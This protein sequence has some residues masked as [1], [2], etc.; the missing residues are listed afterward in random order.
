[1]RA[2]T[3]D[4]PGW[5]AV[6]PTSKAVEQAAASEPGGV[7][8]AAALASVIR[9]MSTLARAGALPARVERVEEASRRLVVY[10]QRH[11]V[12]LYPTRDGDAYRLVRTDPLTF[13]DHERLLRASVLLRCPAGFRPV[14]QLRDLRG[15]QGL[16]AYWP[17]IT[18]AWEAATAD[19]PVLDGLPPQHADYLDLL[20]EAV[21]ATRDIEIEKQSSA[22]PMPY[23]SRGA[24]QAQRD[25]ARGLYSFRL[26]RP[27][28]LAVGAPVS[29][30]DEPGLRGRVVHV[31]DGE[32]VIRFDDAIDYR[33]I[34]PQG[35]LR[36]LPSERVYRAQLAAIDVLREGRA[37][38]P[39]LLETLVDRRLASYSPDGRA[40]PSRSL[41]P[42]QSM[43]FQ[44]ALA[45]PDQLLILG[46]PGT[47]KTRT[48]SEIAAACAA[49]RQRVLVTSHTNRAVDNVLERLPGEV[50]SVR[51]GNEDS[52]TRQA[53][54]FMVETQVDLLR[55]DILSATESSA[56]VLVSVAGTDGPVAPWHRF[57]LNRLADADDADEEVR[58]KTAALGTAIERVAPML[59]SRMTATDAAIADARD[60]V[61]QAAAA[62][63][64][65]R[66]A[67][68]VA[69]T[70]ASSGGLAG[71]VLGWFFGW[72]APR[73]QRR[74]DAAELAQAQARALAA[75]AEAER[76]ALQEQAGIALARDPAAAA[77][78][79][80]RSSA[81]AKRKRAL[82][83]VTDA[84]ARVQDGLLG[85]LPVAG[86]APAMGDAAP[87]AAIEGWQRYASQLGAAI[88]LAGRRAELLEQ[89]RARV[90]APG[91]D[92]HREMVRYADVVAAT[93]IGTE[94]S[95]LL[96]GLGFD[97]A[98]VDEA[99]QISTPNLLVPL[100]RARRSVL[101]GDHHQ[102]PPF[103]DSEVQGWV[104]SLRSSAQADPDRAGRIAGLLKR[105]AFEDCYATADDE[106]RVML[107][108]QRRM[109]A[110]I[111]DFVSRAFYGGS[112]RTEHA[113]NAG[114]P[115]FAR[116]FAMVD[117]ADQPEDQR[118]ERAGRRRSEEWGAHGYVN[119]LEATL[120]TQLVTVCADAYGDWAV[121]VPYRAQVERIRELIAMSLGSDAADSVGTVDAFQG[122]ERDLIVYGFTR[123]NPRGDIGFL[124][125]Q[126][127]LNVAITRARR[128]LV[129][130]GD[131][132]TLTRASDEPFAKLMR[133]LISYLHGNGDIRSSRE[134]AARLRRLATGHS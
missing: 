43:A 59:T 89:W 34:P 117:T 53:R 41:D 124:R 118:R 45:V 40:R 69:Q 100:V 121:I 30:A 51:V 21:E 22:P 68:A 106:H 25:S 80:A 111:A 81:V 12:A 116:P 83:D 98:I 85:A 134:I 48:I 73:R 33:R 37:A 131:T 95:P 42:A 10:T 119:E 2:Q 112:L 19:Q 107:T 123:S 79:Q 102:L 92:L 66:S 58:E 104:D 11:R 15:I 32:V 94:T 7:G 6:V 67:C 28:E 63:A 16:S 57:L 17:A 23:A 78:A 76:V 5:I 129:L 24:G 60:R 70:R 61:R 120:I 130:V 14:N 29:L 90:A 20:T 1:V 91:D 82:S 86:D 77:L 62:V 96:A 75:E 113:G 26:A 46:P 109:P 115:V 47:G 132:T 49:R 108:V 97:L 50:L 4:L 9:D 87:E 13:A 84:A 39:G 72:V 52:M 133:H 103:L 71:L 93:C 110:E 3:A 128:Q 65:A 64:A 18:R 54:R 27:T 38:A 125:E 105:S 127:R 36:V 55:A 126:R 8:S 99:G 88:T 44:R 74:V 122:G 31:S 101:V 114:D 56:S 35:S